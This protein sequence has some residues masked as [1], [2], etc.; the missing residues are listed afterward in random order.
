MINDELNAAEGT[1]I[2][3]AGGN[4]FADGLSIS[5]IAASKGY[6]IVLTDANVLSEEAL[7]TIKKVKPSKVYIAGGTGV[8]SENIED[9]IKTTAGLSEGDI[10][11]IWGQDRYETSLNIA[12]HFDLKSD[13]VT[14]ASGENFPDAL[15]GSVYTAKCS[16]PVILV[17]NDIR[18]QKFYI[19]GKEYLSQV[20]FGGTGVISDTVKANLMK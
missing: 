11:R 16:A 2:V 10:T 9:Q 7:D 14:F 6:P 1:P 13:I 20:I 15:S 19:D 17:S 3:V 18:K 4:V 5:T 8:V 12:K